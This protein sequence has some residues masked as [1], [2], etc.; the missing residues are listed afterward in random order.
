MSLGL[1]SVT[2]RKLSVEQITELAVKAGAEVIEWGGDVHVTD[3][4]SAEKAASLCARAGISI[5]SYGS[6]YR[7][8]TNMTDFEDVCKTAA[9]LGAHIIRVW[10]GDKGSAYT[11]NALLAKL[12]NEA[13]SICDTAARY[14]L[15]VASEFHNNTYNDTSESCLDFLKLA[16][17]SN[18][19][20]YWQ[21][22]YARR[23]TQNLNA[24]VDRTSVVH[25]FYWSRFG[26]RYPLSRGEDRVREFARILRNANYGGDVILEFVK[27]DSPERF[28]E[29]FALLKA[30][31]SE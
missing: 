18:L 16:G 2:F 6:Y 17:K 7:L 25:M 24:V 5:H 11:D 4:P 22:M 8:G 14:N 15:T 9:A 28:I 3:I 29:D 12:V 23:D 26:I 20:T 19:K 1:T 13:R 30:I 31:M 21:P 10:L 27:G